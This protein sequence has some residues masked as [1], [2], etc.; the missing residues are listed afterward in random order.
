[1]LMVAIF[2]SIRYDKYK[3]WGIAYRVCCLLLCLAAIML[4]VTSERIFACRP[5]PTC[6]AL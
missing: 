1:M 4:A 6:I 5:R 3:T 2:R